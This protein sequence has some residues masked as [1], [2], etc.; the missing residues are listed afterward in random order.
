MTK[1][2]YA[3]N[4][5]GPENQTQMQGE[6]YEEFYHTRVKVVNGVVETDDDIAVIGLVA[7]GYEV[8]RD[9]PEADEPEA[10]E[11]SDAEPDEAEAVE[12]EESKPTT[13]KRRGRQK[14]KAT[15]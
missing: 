15:S 1:L 4:D 8:I 10:D 7:R 13:R 6:W 3:L 12:A 2:R 5:R 11:A 9:V 14:A